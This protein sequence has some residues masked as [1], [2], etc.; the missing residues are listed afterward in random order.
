MKHLLE[1]AARGWD[2]AERAHAD[3]DMIEYGLAELFLHRTNIIL[4]E[5]GANL[6]GV[7][8]GRKGE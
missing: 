2:D 7:E 6:R 8:S 4:E 3:W 1:I 5:I